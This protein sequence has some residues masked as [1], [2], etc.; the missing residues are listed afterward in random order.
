LHSPILTIWLPISTNLTQ[1]EGVDCLPNEEIFTTL[2]RMGYEKS[3]TKLTFYKAFFSIREPENQGDAEAQGDAEEQGNDDN[4]TEEPVTAVDDGADFPMSLLQEALD[5]CAALAR[6]VEHLEHDKRIKSSDDTIIEDVSKQGRMINESDKDEVEVVTTAKLITEVVAAVSET[7]SDAAVVQA[8]VPA[9]PVNDAVVEE[10][11]AKTPTETKS[12]DKGKD[13]FKG[14]SYD[15]IH[16]IFEAKFNANMEF[17]LKSKEQMEKE[18]SRA[19]AIINE[20][21]AQKAAKRR[22]LNKEAEDVEELK[23][24]LEI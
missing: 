18:D 23:Q 9:A 17:L 16:P 19:I 10:S 11:S 21:P 14:M 15:D 5:A 13:Y 4:A 8:D 22:R 20:T 12:K 7:V 3:S 24:H 6:R 2:A 1:A